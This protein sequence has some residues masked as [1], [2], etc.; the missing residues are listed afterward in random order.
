M[1]EREDI[2]LTLIWP[3]HCRMSFRAQNA[4]KEKI[5]FMN[6]YIY[7]RL[8]FNHIV[9]HGTADINN[10]RFCLHYR[11]NK[12]RKKKKSK[13]TTTTETAA[14]T[15][16]TTSRN[17]NNKTKWEMKITTRNDW[18]IEQTWKVEWTQEK[19]IFVNNNKNLP[20]TRSQILR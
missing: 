7:I 11:K 13:T 10:Y 16:T 4:E 15:T 17:N 1:L 20:A 18:A 14:T 12:R 8:I 5:I 19:R 9:R 6:T 2:S 3:K